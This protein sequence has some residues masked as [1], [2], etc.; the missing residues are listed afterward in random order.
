MQ[1]R[2]ALR[3]RRI[4][5]CPGSQQHADDLCVSSAGNLMQ[6]RPA[7]RIRR[8]DRSPVSKCLFEL[9]KVPVFGCLPKSS[10]HLWI[11]R[12]GWCRCG[13]TSLR[14]ARSACGTPYS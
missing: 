4:D 7:V 5:L 14:G 8:I 10:L 3:I 9:F 1:R 6:Q 2:P 13:R 11:D 12:G